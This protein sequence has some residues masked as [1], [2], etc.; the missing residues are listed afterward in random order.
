MNNCLCMGCLRLWPTDDKP[1]PVCGWDI[2]QEWHCADAV[3]KLRAGVLQ[4]RELGISVN[5]AEWS[6]DGG[7]VIALAHHGRPVRLSLSY[8]R[9]QSN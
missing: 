8:Q 5:L 1:C 4:G 3:A 2:E 7:G 9:S 6:A